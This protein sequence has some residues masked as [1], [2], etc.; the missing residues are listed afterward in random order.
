VS[1]TVARGLARILVVLV[2]L[3]GAAGCASVDRPLA[4]ASPQDQLQIAQMRYDHRDYTEAITLLQAFIQYNA[5]SPDLDRAHFMLGM[6]HV[7]RKEWPLAATEFMVVTTD[8][9]DS[10]MLADAH[11]WLGV[12]YWRQSRPAA[13]DQDATRRSIAQWQRFLN[14]Y[15]DHP[16]AAEGRD[17]LLQA[18]T[19]LAEKSIKNARLYVVLKYWR[20]ALVYFDEVVNDYA[21]TP[22]FDWALVGRAEALRG[23]GDVAEARAALEQ[24]M[25]RLKDAEAKARAEE[26]LH[27]LPPVPA[28]GVPAADGNPG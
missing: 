5:Q 20:G 17:F 23:Q 28:P 7:Q 10:P 27:D 2:S 18:R 1:S 15:P 19:R 24:A 6:C 16:R 13:Y 4:P 3:A 26:L 22:W 14:L 21:D 9:P 25:P 11:Y 12:S 8:F